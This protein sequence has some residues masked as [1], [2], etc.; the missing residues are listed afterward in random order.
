MDNLNVDELKKDLQMIRSKIERF[1]N[2]NLIDILLEYYKN[3]NKIY[4][5]VDC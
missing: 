3:N 4:K 5:V 1:F 2:N